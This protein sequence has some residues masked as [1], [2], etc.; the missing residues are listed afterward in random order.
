[1]VMTKIIIA[2]VAGILFTV[3]FFATPAE[4]LHGT[5]LPALRQDIIQLFGITTDHE[6][7]ISQLEVNNT[8]NVP[9]VNVTNKPIGFAD[10][11]DNDTNTQLTE[12]QVDAFVSNNG[13]STGPHTIDTNLNEAQVDSFVSNN[14]FLNQTDWNTDL[15]NIPSG[16]ADGIDDVGTDTL[17]GLGCTT[18]QIAKFNGTQWICD[19]LQSTVDHTKIYK[20]EGNDVFV[21]AGNISSSSEAF[22]DTGDLVLSGGYEDAPGSGQQS[23][24]SWVNHMT[25]S[26]TGWSAA[27]VAKKP[28]VNKI[29]ATIAIIILVITILSN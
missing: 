4:A 9:W 22:C 20:V 16:F 8:S 27:G 18:D 19:N 11:I 7:R 29:P 14:G 2:I 3:G 5:N 21:P 17:L 1:M 23:I 28:T 12:I 24:F 15:I 26:G 13:F 10:N 25:D 6:N